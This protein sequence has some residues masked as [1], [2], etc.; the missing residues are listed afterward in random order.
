MTL[1]PSPLWTDQSSA[2]RMTGTW[3][4]AI[5]V[6]QT[7]VSPCLTACPIDGRIAEWIGQIGQHSYFEAWQTLVDNN[8][9]PA[10]IGRICHHPCQTSCNR[11][12]LDETVG[13]CSLERF[14]G[15]MALEQG[16]Q[17]EE[18]K[19]LCSQS[20]AIIGGGPAGLSAAYH[21]L[22]AGY[23]VTLYERQPK[24]GGLLRY[25]IPAYRLER[26][27]LDLEIA[28]IVDLGLEVKLDA[29][30]MDS[31]A[32]RGLRDRFDA[33]YMATGASTP[34]R[35]A[36]LDYDQP[37]VID[38]A[39]FLAASN[40]ETPLDLGGRVVVIGGGSAALDVARTA[41][42]LG[43]EVTVLSLEPE[44]QLPAQ[45]AEIREAVEE[46][47]TFVGGA[48]MQSVNE[49]RGGLRLTCCHV[50]FARATTRGD[51]S[52]EPLDD[53]QFALTT[54]TII[55]SIGQD[56]DV[57]RWAGL[58]EQTGALAQTGP[59]GQTAT[60]GIYAGGDLASMDRFV[61]QAIGMG[62][63]AAQAIAAGFHKPSTPAVMPASPA[64]FD[65]INTAYQIR[66]ARQRQ[67][68]TEPAVRLQS[69]DEVQQPLDID[70]ALAEAS[71]CF[72]CGTCTYCDNCYF[73]CPDMAITKLDHGYLVNA[74]YCKGCGLCVAE[75]PTGS[76]QM[77]GEM[78][79]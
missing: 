75:C 65:K 11:E 29:E 56:A 62:K 35:L 72:S 2:A 20:V 71:R 5:P 60:A 76:V 44:G 79:Q 54:D 18:P 30:V 37:Y 59:D 8:P 51:F 10:V 24:L 31:T 25:G 43:R 64:G 26:R 55:P 40:S 3:R 39:E 13:I 66:A 22:R 28:R 27:V 7:L 50:S 15:D 47:V 12:N 57:S 9:F 77:I 6:Y 23:S 19:V 68:N 53:G 34:K 73:Y 33:V 74:D 69:F 38:S 49:E 63:Q 46:G 16:W 45:A 70:A 32:L 67:A 58:I 36:G 4:S 42:R 21:L 61:S 52:V 1:I 17:F 41:R 14:V 78:V 48:M